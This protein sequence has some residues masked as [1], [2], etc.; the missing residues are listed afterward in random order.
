MTKDEAINFLEQHQPMPDDDQMSDVVI[1]QY[2]SVRKYSI[3][4][5]DPACIPLFLNSFGKGSGCGVYQVVEDVMRQFPKRV[6][7][8]HLVEG[9]AGTNESAQEWCAYIAASFPESELVSPLKDLLVN[10]NM[11]ARFA[12]VIALEQIDEP[13]VDVILQMALDVEADDELREMI[14][15]ALTDRMKGTDGAEQAGPDPE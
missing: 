7:V 9:I 13:S 4:N 11:N 8:P 12:S 10:G 1:D 3:E 15:S 6:V 2:E 14:E 5:P